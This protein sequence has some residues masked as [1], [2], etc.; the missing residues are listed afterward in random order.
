MML[1]LLA[2]M[3]LATPNDVELRSNDVLPVGRNDVA[4]GK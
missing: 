1:C 3:M 4:C 2:Q